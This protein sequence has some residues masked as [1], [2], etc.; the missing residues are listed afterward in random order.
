MTYPATLIRKNVDRVFAMENSKASKSA[1]KISEDY[2]A[3]K[4]SSAEA[5][6]KIKVAHGI[7]LNTAAATHSK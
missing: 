3:R 5:I 2:L 6:E 1:T 7:N 4:C